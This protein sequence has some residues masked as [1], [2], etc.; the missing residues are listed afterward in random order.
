MLKVTLIPILEDNYS[1]II[2]SGDVVGIIDPS[3]AKPIIEFL[4][5]NNLTPSFIFNTHHH[6]DHVN[7][8][9]KIKAKYNCKIIGSDKEKNKIPDIDTPLFDGD[10]FKFGNETIKIIGTA[11]HTSGHICFFFKEAK[12]LFSGD[13]LFSLGC[14]RLFEGTAQQL[15]NS[16]ERLKQLPD[17]TKIYCGHEYTLENSEF[18]IQVDPDN[19]KLIERIRE[20]KNLRNK[21]QPTIPTTLAQEKETNSFL[22]AKSAEELKKLRELKDSL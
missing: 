22:R 19:K 9:K 17:D 4:E 16:F 21:N 13:T 14:G 12:V 18:C 15:Y 1:Y 3:E 20:A 6:W 11:G 10:I 2:Q 7:G 8:N 5:K